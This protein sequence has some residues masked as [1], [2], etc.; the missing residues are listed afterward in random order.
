MDV[1]A[2]ERALSYIARGGGR[3]WV[4]LDPHGGLGGPALI[5]LDAGMEPPGVSKATRRKRSARRTHRFTEF[6][7]VGF[8]LRCDFGK[9]DPPKEL[10][11]VA[12]RYPARLEAFWDGAI[13]V[14]DDLPER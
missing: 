13:F 2:D 11:L 8:E 9:F 1:V 5:Y 12:R 6:P 14:T 4:W 7:A 10:H 3:V